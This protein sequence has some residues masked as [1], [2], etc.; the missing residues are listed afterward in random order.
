MFNNQQTCQLSMVITLHKQE[1]KEF[2]SNLSKIITKNSGSFVRFWI[3]TIVN[4]KL[5][6]EEKLKE[7]SY[8]VSLLDNM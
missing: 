8:P 6:F 4:T 7:A 2:I 5:L 3:P 1:S